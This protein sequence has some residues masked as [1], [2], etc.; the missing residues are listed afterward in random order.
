[1]G[2]LKHRR[3]AFGTV[4]AV[5]LTI[6]V[7]L[8]QARVDFRVLSVLYIAINSILIIL[9]SLVG[10]ILLMAGY[11]VVPR[12][13]ARVWRALLVNITLHTLQRVIETQSSMVQATAIGERQGSVVFRLETGSNSGVTYGTRFTVSN[14]ATGEAWGVIEAVEADGYSCTC[15]V[16]DR[17]NPEF[18]DELEARMRRDASP[19]QGVTIKRAFPEDIVEIINNLLNSWRR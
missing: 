10:T 6:V 3:F 9:M 13:L 17:I 16:L 15:I 7:L 12:L 4:F 8:F 5:V 14:T 11:F 19:P 2:F 18:W 1:M